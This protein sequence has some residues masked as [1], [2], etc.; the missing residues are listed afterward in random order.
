M[1]TKTKR[2]V[3]RT[4]RSKATNS[5]DLLDDVSAAILA[6]PARANMYTWLATTREGILGR[7][8]VIDGSGVTKGVRAPRVPACGTVGCIAGWVTALQRGKS[9]AKRLIAAH[10]RS[11]GGFSS[12]AHGLLNPTGNQ[13]MR[14]DIFDLFSA[15]GFSSRPGTLKHAKEIVAKIRAFQLKYCATLKTTVIPRGA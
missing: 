3:V 2:R 14:G 12:D 1:K 9:K 10:M 7:F 11:D 13:P 15:I 8:D 5:Y 4:P 6:E